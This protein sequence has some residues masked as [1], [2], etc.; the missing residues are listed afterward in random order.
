[1]DGERQYSESDLARLAAQLRDPAC[2]QRS[3]RGLMD[4]L[5]L[6]DSASTRQAFERAYGCSPATYRRGAVAVV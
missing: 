5:Q 3:L 2:A 6:S 1:M 4:S